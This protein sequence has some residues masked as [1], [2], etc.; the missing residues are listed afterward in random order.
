MLSRRSPPKYLEADLLGPVHYVDFGGSGRALVL[1]HGLGGSHANW[2]AS[3]SELTEYGRVL[4]LDLAG[5]GRTRSLGRKA[6]VGA[7][8]R[9][10]GRFLDEVVGEPAVLVGNS[11]GGYLVMAEAAAEPAKVTSLV[12]VNPAVPIA[13]HAGFDAQVLA[14]FT[15]M[16]IPVVGELL[17]HLQGRSPE[18][19]VRSLLALCCADPTLV[20][21]H[22][23]EAHVALARERASYGRVVTRDFLAAQ[24]SLMV[25]LLKRREF[26]AMVSRIACPALVVQGDRDRLVKLANARALAAS[27]PDWDLEVLEGVGHVPQLE[28]PERFV[29]V[30]GRWLTTR[31]G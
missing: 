10:L 1:V 23:L 7:N 14:L 9:L 15:A 17:V 20:S 2:L 4:A 8:R 5:H 6:T 26:A 21:E 3:A 30:V 24:R 13:H 29:A 22:I 25:R 28:V 11:M 31:A 19:T 12:L 27:R 16:A 18:R